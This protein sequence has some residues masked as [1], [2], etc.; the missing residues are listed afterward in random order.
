[1]RLAHRKSPHGPVPSPRNPRALPARLLGKYDSPHSLAPARPPGHNTGRRLRTRANEA[2]GPG[3]SPQA[4]SQGGADPGH[5]KIH[6]SRS[7]LRRSKWSG[8][9]SR[10][11]S[12]HEARRGRLLV[13]ENLSA[14]HRHDPR[15]PGRRRTKAPPLVLQVRAPGRHPSRHWGRR[16]GQNGR[17]PQY[18]ERRSPTTAQRENARAVQSARVARLKVPRRVLVADREAGDWPGPCAP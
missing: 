12:L 7:R 4:T 15:A 13:R 16:S 1:M 14:P 3:R 11:T 9:A 6:D 18:D 10:A 2:P 5:Q 8:R 17:V